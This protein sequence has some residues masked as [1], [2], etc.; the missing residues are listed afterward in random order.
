MVEKRIEQLK[1]TWIKNV[2]KILGLSESQ[3]LEAYNRIQPYKF[4][5]VSV[6][7]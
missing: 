2:T 3:A 6:A 7:Q 5:E 1:K 4:L